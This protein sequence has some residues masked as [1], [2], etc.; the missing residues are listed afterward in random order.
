MIVTLQT[1]G[2][3][4]LEQ[5]RAFMAG[6]APVS[7]TLTDAVSARVWMTEPLRRF[8]YGTLSRSDKGLL[9][10]YLTKIT[11]LSRAQMTRR[12][13]EFL[14]CGAIKDR[15]RAP[16]VSFVRR[17][18]VEYIRLLAKMDVLHHTLSGPA[19]KKLIER[20][21]QVFGDVRFEQLAGISVSHLYNLRGS[22]PY[23]NKRRHWTKTNPTGV[24]IG[25]RRAPQLPSYISIDK[26]TSRRPGRCQRR[27]SHQRGRLCD[28][29]AAC[30]DVRKDQ[31]GLFAAG[32]PAVTGRISVCHSGIS[33]G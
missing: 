12:I 30:G 29:D 24:P 20:A 14:A 3:H 25:Q 16:V 10:R 22:R 32:H 8:G 21:H 18:T 4:T 11:G 27:V 28:A 2:L 1:Q 31:R 33:L 7:F 5:V 15:R 23:L 9:R 13:A 19:T 6:N 26:R 17:Y